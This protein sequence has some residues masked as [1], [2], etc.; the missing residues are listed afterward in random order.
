MSAFAQSRKVG[1]RDCS[2]AAGSCT[3]CSTKRPL[4]QRRAASTGSF[5]FIP[6]VVGEV[7]QSPGQPL[8]AETRGAMED[9]FGVDFSG[10][11]VHSDAAAASSARAIDATAYTVGRDVVFAAEAYRPHSS[12]GRELLAHEL[13]HVVQQ[14]HPGMPGVS[15]RAAE[16]DA[17]NAAGRAAQG[18]HATVT[19]RA[20]S[21]ILRQP[22][23][24]GATQEEDDPLA[25]I[26]RINQ[27]GA[28][29][30]PRISR[31]RQPT[32]SA[33]D[34]PVRPLPPDQQWAADALAGKPPPAAGQRAEDPDRTRQDSNSKNGSVWDTLKPGGLV[35]EALDSVANPKNAVA[36]GIMDNLD[37]RGAALLNT[38]AALE[39]L[40]EKEGAAGVGKALV[41]GVGFL[42][43][44]TGD[45]A[46][47]IVAELSHYQGAKSDEKIA[48]RSLD[49]LLNT[50][51]LVTIVAGGAG[52]AKG[53]VAAARGITA[54]VEKGAI[55]ISQG[56][57]LL[58]PALAT[59][60][61]E[62]RGGE[63]SLVAA[64]STGTL[65]APGLK[66]VA[67]APAAVGAAGQASGGSG[68][69]GRR[70]ASPTLEGFE[71]HKAPGSPRPRTATV[72]REEQLFGLP[73]KTGL[74]QPKT[75][76]RRSSP[77][78]GIR[79]RIQA[80]L[81]AGAPDPVFPGRTVR[82]V[83]H[84]DHIVSLDRIRQKPGFARIDEARQIEILNLE[85]NFEALSEAANTSKGSRTY[86]EWADHLRSRGEVFNQTYVDSMIE[87]EDR[88]D[89]VIDRMIQ[90]SPQW[91]TQP[92]SP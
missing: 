82:G 67:T 80:A 59:A 60:G 55:T 56:A 28:I 63:A 87:A 22:A 90:E 51:D 54:G 5:G 46:V 43:R 32:L 86:R 58:Q 85:E 34:A 17:N 38:R 78:P 19:T 62:L 44:D 57:R 88:L 7:L 26:R 65:A 50:A 91:G 33:I 74:K 27:F 36:K 2:C 40:Y 89:A 12:A 31:A 30:F 20:P 1:H 92:A 6:S 9:S 21:G 23:R 16:R 70:A 69:V 11:R 49:I 84:A 3:G 68:R 77:T 48:S 71:S 29:A 66:A 53:G 72:T 35:F 75:V 42:V 52:A 8:N 37:K 25:L 10:V 76:I 47:D 18:L 4:L 15:P 79:E 24:A 41:V 14:A 83:A 39:G 45:A 81:P 61:A 73:R 13:A 64:G